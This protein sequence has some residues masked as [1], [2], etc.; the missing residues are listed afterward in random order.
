[1][2]FFSNISLKNYPK[3]ILLNQDYDQLDEFID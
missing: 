3:I 1:M 2:S